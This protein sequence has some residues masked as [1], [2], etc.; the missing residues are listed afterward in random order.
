M[1][2]EDGHLNQERQHLQST[3][4]NKK[5]QE[6]ISTLIKEAPKGQ[7]FKQNLEDDIHKDI[8]P[9]SDLP[10]IKTHQL[11]FSIIES[12]HVRISYTCITVW[13]YF[14]SSRGNEYMLISYY[15]DANAILAEPIKNRQA[16]TITQVWTKINNKF[17]S[18]GIH[19]HT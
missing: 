19:P 17:V 11:I 15:Y 4:T 1:V 7:P 18:A 6:R 9:P 10:N 16:E 2:T 12:S 13:F 8:F 14:R 5:I 3:S